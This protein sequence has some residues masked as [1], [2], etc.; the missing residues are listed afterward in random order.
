MEAW[1]SHWRCHSSLKGSWLVGGSAH[2]K[3][4][5]SSNG[6]DSSADCEGNS[7]RNQSDYGGCT[8]TAVGSFAVVVGGYGGGGYYDGGAGFGPVDSPSN[9]SAGCYFQTNSYL[10]CH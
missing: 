6:S 10:S 7:D 2:S 3:A 5:H 1:H 9:Y 8:S 4:D